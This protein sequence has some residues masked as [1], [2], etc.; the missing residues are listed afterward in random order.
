[1]IKKNAMNRLLIMA[2]KEKSVMQNIP[3]NGYSVKL[4]FLHGGVNNE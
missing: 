1:M 2:L 3:I 4:F